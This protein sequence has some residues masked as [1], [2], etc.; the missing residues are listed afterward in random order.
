MSLRTDAAILELLPELMHTEIALLMALSQAASDGVVGRH[1]YILAI[2]RAGLTEA[3]A[4]RVLSG[5]SLQGMAHLH[6]PTQDRPGTLHIQGAE[7][8]E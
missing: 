7:G 2:Q 4:D 5:L 8:E 3:Q 6:R 1:A